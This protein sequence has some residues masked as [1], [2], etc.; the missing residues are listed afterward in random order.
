M[1]DELEKE[2]LYT[3]VTLDDLTSGYSEGYIESFKKLNSYE[4]DGLV[5]V[6]ADILV[7]NKTFSSYIDEKLIPSRIKIMNG[8]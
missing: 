2:N 1:D 6:E 3:K 8:K 4:E 7:R 5:K